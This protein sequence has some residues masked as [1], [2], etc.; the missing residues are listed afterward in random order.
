M[1][2]YLKIY[3]ISV[4]V[5][6]LLVLFNAIIDPYGIFTFSTISSEKWTK[7]EMVNNVKLH[8]SINV[9][10]L[11]PKAV[12]IGTSRTA[13]GIDPDN[14]IWAKS[15]KPNYNLSLAGGNVYIAYRYLE[16]AHTIS[17]LKQVI[18]G[19]DFFTFN[20]HRPQASDYR[21]DFLIVNDDGSYNPQYKRN[22]LSASLLSTTALE[23]SFNTITEK[24]NSN[25]TISDNGLFIGPTWK[26]HLHKSFIAM[27]ELYFQHVYLAGKNKEYAFLN[28]KSGA[29]SLEDFRKLIIYCSQQDIDLKLFIS[30]LHARHQEVIKTLGLWPLFEQWKREIV[31]ILANEDYTSEL[32]DFS[33]YNSVTTDSIG[34]DSNN[35]YRDSTHY[36]P[37]IGDMILSRLFHHNDNNIPYDFGRILM[38]ENIE[39]HL[40]SI[41]AEQEK[42]NTSHSDDSNEIKKMA[43]KFNFDVENLTLVN[44]GPHSKATW[45]P[46]N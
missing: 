5:I 26:G 11:K 39:E 8:K 32:W 24:D 17:P 41:R 3:I 20:I 42:Y 35:Y 7:V 25:I 29:S 30:P 36:H 16:H 22:I 40:A 31:T 18:F 27:E 2:N 4:G 14:S 21:G 9:S 6:L 43:I 33:G 15:F 45:L 28:P 13:F 12:A 19:L 1:S 23:A 38:P 46:N 44:N 37:I 34:S 10:R